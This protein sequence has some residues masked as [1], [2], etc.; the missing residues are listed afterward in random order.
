MD[1]QK[2]H[3]GLQACIEFL[4]RLMEKAP[5]EPYRLSRHS[6][7]RE[8]VANWL[9]Y[10]KHSETHPADILKV[11]I[12]MLLMREAQPGLFR[13]DRHFNHQ[14]VIRVLRLSSKRGLRWKVKKPSTVAVCVREILSDIL[15]K[16]NLTVFCWK[17]AQWI[18]KHDKRPQPLP[19][20][21]IIGGISKPFIH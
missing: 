2:G 16:S 6:S 3:E 5:H 4:H 7:D 13:S 11:V 15:V 21:H 17:A 14:T 20:P 8:R 19:D 1:Q 12:G 10:L 9:Y 18:E